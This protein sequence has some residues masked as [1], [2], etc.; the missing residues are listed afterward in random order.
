MKVSDLLDKKAR[1]I[2][3]DDVLL[4]GELERKGKLE[5]V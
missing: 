3:S 1:G 2:F 4:K 5:T